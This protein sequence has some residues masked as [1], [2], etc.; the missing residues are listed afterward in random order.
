MLSAQV[1]LLWEVLLRKPWDRKSWLALGRHGYKFF[2]FQAALGW[3]WS[4]GSSH[5]DRSES[6]KSA[7]PRPRP[8]SL[9]HRLAILVSPDKG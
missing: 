4:G 7:L 9:W 1:S 5:K 8:F 6:L 3:G 2:T